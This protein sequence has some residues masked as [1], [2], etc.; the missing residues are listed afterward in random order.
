MKNLEDDLLLFL[1]VSRP[2]THF[3][4]PRIVGVDEWQLVEIRLSLSDSQTLDSRWS[5]LPSGACFQVELVLRRRG[6]GLPDLKSVPL[7][8][9]RPFLPSLLLSLNPPGHC[10]NGT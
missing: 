9:A 6:E 3:Q 5:L 2:P 4:N 8:L 7:T 1:H 10:L